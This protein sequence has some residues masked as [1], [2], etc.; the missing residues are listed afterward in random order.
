M[1]LV[2]LICMI[3]F[4]Y[5]IHRMNEIPEISSE[6]YE[7]HYALITNEDDSAFW[8]KVYESAYEAGKENGVYVE[9]FGSQLAVDYTRNELIEL[10]IQA[11]VDGIILQ[12]DEGQETMELLNQAVEAGIPVVTML[13][14]SPGSLRQCFVGMNNYNLGQEYGKQVAAL[15]KEKL[16]DADNPARVLVLMDED[17]KDS[18]QNLI[19]LGIRET[20]KQLL[21]KDY[22]VTVETKQIDSAGSLRSE[23]SIR[24]I[25]LNWSV[26]PDIMICLN[27]VNT[28]C[29]FQATVDYNEVGNVQILGYYDSEAILDAV[30][31][32]IVYAT[33]APDT[34]QM[35]ED[36]VM[37]LEEYLNTGYTNGYM[38]VN[39]ALIKSGEAVERLNEK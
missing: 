37:A 12:G 4:H 11:S 29:V 24:D 21:G 20:M 1:I 14:D 18:S 39:A 38:A 5:G 9:R 19:L 31:K 35:G 8:D 25:F 32:N 16:E 23:E 17:R 2:T 6:T 26:L 33:I 36:C 7:R 10:A 30:A 3:V 13:T 28:R 34:K 15:L 27:E 22:P